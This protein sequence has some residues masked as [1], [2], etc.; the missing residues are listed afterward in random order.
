M[1]SLRIK[2]DPP[3]S[4]DLIIGGTR[5]VRWIP[6]TS[7]IDP[8]V[9]MLMRWPMTQVTGTINLA[10]HCAWAR[11]GNRF[12]T[13][14]LSLPSAIGRDRNESGKIAICDPTYAIPISL[15]ARSCPPH[16]PFLQLVYLSRVSVVCHLGLPYTFLVC[17]HGSY[18]SDRANLH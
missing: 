5:P 18:N 3:F 9:T 11:S 10:D 6:N 2:A 14:S 4:W 7:R 1:H 12:D 15:L 16:S 8:S 13:H 17:T